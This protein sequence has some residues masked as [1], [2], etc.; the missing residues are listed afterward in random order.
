MSQEKDASILTHFASLEDPRDNRGKEH[1][2]IDII[3]IALCTI[4]SGGEGWEDMAE[5]GNAKEEWLSTFLSLRN[6]IPCA[7]TFARVFARI[8]PEAFQACFSGWVRAISE[9]ITGEV[10]SIDGKTLR[11]SY[12]KNKSKAAIQVV[13]AWASEQ[14]LVLGQRQ[15]DK[16][17]NEITAI[18]ELLQILELSGC[19][20]TIDAMGCQKEIAQ[21][22]VEQQADYVIALKGN[23]GGLYEDVQWLFEQAQATDFQGVAHDF[24][25]T[26]DK[27]HGRLEIRRCWT[28]SALEYLV[29]KPLWS[30]LQTI[31]MVERECRFAHQI[32]TETRFFI[33]SLPSNAVKIAQAVR[34]HWSIENS[35]HWVLDVSFH[36]DNSRIRRDHAPENMALLRHFALNLLSQDKST[37]RGIAAR[38]KKA[39]WHH[40]YLVK[41]LTQ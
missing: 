29:Q 19:I 21:R 35:L 14:R 24:V 30:G 9:R 22:I 13:S 25:R 33:S 4:L 6:G 37:R 12:D 31:V 20:V 5:Y 34:S 41:L 40:P 1:L 2:L 26:V 23:Q 17:S 28:L 36:E 3:T 7:D 39:A 38:R 18:P 15:V 8:D 10:I 16:K 27:G 11:H 32:T